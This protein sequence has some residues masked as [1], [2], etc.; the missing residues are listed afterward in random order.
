MQTDLGNL[1]RSCITSSYLR[2]ICKNVF[3][4]SLAYQMQCAHTYREETCFWTWMWSTCVLHT[5]KHLCFLGMGRP[6]N[7]PVPQ[8]TINKLLP[9]DGFELI[10]YR[11]ETSADK[12]HHKASLSHICTPLYPMH[13]RQS[14]LS[15]KKKKKWASSYCKYLIVVCSSFRNNI[16]RSL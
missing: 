2:Q 9:P 4:E 14:H 12:Y 5:S 10:T 16:S 3:T 15:M 7:F 8:K 11:L 1:S 6:D 13:S